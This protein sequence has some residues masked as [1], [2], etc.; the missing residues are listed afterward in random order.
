MRGQSCLW[1]YSKPCLPPPHYPL[2]T[3]LPYHRLSEDREQKGK[4]SFSN[5]S[6]R[7]LTSVA[8]FTGVGG[9]GGGGGVAE[10]FWIRLRFCFP[11]LTSYLCWWTKRTGLLWVVNKEFALD[12]SAGIS[13]SDAQPVIHG[14]DP[15]ALSNWHCCCISVRHSTS[16][17]GRC[18]SDELEARISFF[19]LI[20]FPLPLVMSAVRKDE[21][22]SNAL[23]GF[24]FK[25][26]I[27]GGL[28]RPFVALKC[29]KC[30][31]LQNVTSS[32]GHVSPPAY[33]H[34]PELHPIS[35]GNFL[36]LQPRKLDH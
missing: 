22:I 2:P 27:R 33:E 17:L 31:S 36:W 15:C 32:H 23:Q 26:D 12:A 30:G 29:V 7:S 24:T 21:G 1:H 5:P 3:F 6:Q 10:S 9:G 18:Y 28:R 19:N 14:W 35:K 25:P 34:R 8:K 13:A 16:Y 20:F 11:A 4:H